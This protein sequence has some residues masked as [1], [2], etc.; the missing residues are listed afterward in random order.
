VNEETWEPFN[1]RSFKS[2]K[3]RNNFSFENLNFSFSFGDGLKT[4]KY[5]CPLVIS[6]RIRPKH[7]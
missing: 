4:S 5:P 2:K 1:V 7:E 3:I 6:L